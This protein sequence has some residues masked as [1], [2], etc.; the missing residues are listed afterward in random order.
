MVM[1]SSK[2]TAVGGIFDMCC[3]DYCS[4]GIRFPVHLRGWNEESNPDFHMGAYLL[5]VDHCS[6]FQLTPLNT[7][8]IRNAW[9]MRNLVKLQ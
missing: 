4:M 9:A 3:R 7:S 2:L 6:S 8:G 5:R 1:G